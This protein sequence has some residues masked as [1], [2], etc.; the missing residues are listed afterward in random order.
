MQTA[1][2]KMIDTSTRLTY[3]SAQALKAHGVLYAARYL[4]GDY[5]MAVE[6][7]TAC[8]RAGLPLISIFETNPT[9]K[10]YFVPNRGTQDAKAARAAAE[11][12]GQPLHTSIFAT[13][14]YNV[15]AEDLPAV[16]N[17]FKE[18][19]AA[20]EG[21][22]V[23]GAYGDSLVMESLRRSV[24]EV[25]K[26]WQ[27]SAWSTKENNEFLCAYQYLYDQTLADVPVDLSEV[28]VDPG[29][30]LADIH[31]DSPARL[32]NEVV[33]VPA[34]EIN[35]QPHGTGL[36]VKMGDRF[37]TYLMAGVVAQY[38]PMLVAV[39]A[40]QGKFTYRGEPV[41][42]VVIQAQIAYVPW[43]YLGSTAE[44]KTTGGWDF[45]VPVVVHTPTIQ[46]GEV[47]GQFNIIEVADS[48]QFQL[49]GKGESIIA[50]PMT[51]D[52][53]AFE[54]MLTKDIA[55]ALGLPNLGDMDLGGVGGGGVQSYRSKV[56]F[57]IGEEEFTEVNCVV[58]TDPAYTGN[59][60]FGLRFA[61]DHGLDFDV[62]LSERRIVF[63]RPNK[64]EVSV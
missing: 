49:H 29:A 27:T 19:A 7:V 26:F 2:G 53:G 23:L 10:A 62:Q 22:Y 5:A 37:V 12:L 51:F 40:L 47:I 25:Q 59:P 9:S 11:K 52:T 4:V 42:D 33:G 57:V 16:A 8:A 55:E 34:I 18:F 31:P 6:E 56:S 45:T 61:I 15:A 41:T 60:L 32:K 38:N 1:I 17:Y 39:D 30:W 46:N 58:N 50:S 63:Y 36:D 13:V 44:K 64:K 24:P 35:G 20:L 54:M 3:E 21:Q 43:T 28:Y 14:D 48:M